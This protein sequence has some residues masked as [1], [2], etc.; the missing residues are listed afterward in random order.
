VVDGQGKGG[1]FVLFWDD[2]IN[3]RILSYGLHYIDTLIWD[4]DHHAH[5]RGTSVYGEART[6]DRGDMW[7]LLRCL[8]PLYMVPWMLICDF[9]EDK[10]SFEQFS[11]RKR[12][13]GQM[14]NFC[15]V[16]EYCEVYDMGFSGLPWTFDN[17]QKGDRNVKVRLDRVVASN[18][19]KDWFKD[20]HVSHLVSSRLDHLPILLELSQE[21]EYGKIRNIARYEIMWESD[22]SLPMRLNM[23]GNP[24]FRLSTWGIL[25]EN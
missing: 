3:I 4:A 22:E 1:G 2:S 21:A 25:L 19:W 15:D 23:H 20:A 10:W 12:P 17:K 11:S 8:K 18:S 14:H 24:V 16:L 9:N 6:H 7:K 13:E 5:W